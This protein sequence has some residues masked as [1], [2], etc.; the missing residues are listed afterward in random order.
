MIE[1]S[2]ALLTLESTT[3]AKVKAST[4]TLATRTGDRLAEAADSEQDLTGTQFLSRQDVDDA[5]SE[6]LAADQQRVQDLT[7]AA[8]TAAALLALA[9]LTTQFTELGHDVPQTLPSLGTGLGVLLAA[10]AAAHSEA[11]ATAH[12]LIRKGY[13][14]IDSDDP[15][16]FLAA[17]K[18]VLRGAANR[19][20]KTLGARSLAS[21][22]VAVHQGYTDAELAIFREFEA[23]NPYVGIRKEWLVQS[24]SPCHHCAA[25]DGTQILV[26]G[27]FDPAAS[28]DK[29]AL[30]VPWPTSR[31]GPP[32]H[33]NCRCRLRLVLAVTRP[34]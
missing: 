8:Y 13:D 4:G 29:D 25:L 30:T 12:D 9:A 5:L 17:L 1:Q 14:G 6:E 3:R 24:A 21:A 31:Q 20:A 11:K 23:I 10:V 34:A 2:T 19:T 22:V 32:R 7:T 15:K 33:P 16:A 27:T 18:Q 26:T 28:T